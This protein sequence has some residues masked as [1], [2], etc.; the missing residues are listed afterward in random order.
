MNVNFNGP[1]N[2][3]KA[4]LPVLLKRQVAQIANV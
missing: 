1:V 2:L 3:I 4:F